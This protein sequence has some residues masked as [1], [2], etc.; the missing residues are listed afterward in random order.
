MMIWHLQKQTFLNDRLWKVGTGRLGREAE[1][2]AD[3]M[4]DPLLTHTGRP[5]THFSHST[6]SYT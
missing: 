2:H 6:N 1:V 5:V 3:F 4:T